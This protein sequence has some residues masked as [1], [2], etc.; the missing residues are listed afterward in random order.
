MAMPCTSSCSAAVTTSSTERLCPRWITSAPM[1]CRMR[2]MMLMAASW[3]SKSEAAVTKRTLFVGRYSARALNSA[4][5]S[6]MRGSCTSFDND[7][8]QRRVARR[9][10]QI[11]ALHRLLHHCGDHQIA[12]RFRICG[13]DG[14]RGP[15]CAGG[16]DGGRIRRLIGI[17]FL[18]R[19]EVA[20]FELPVLGRVVE[21]LLQTRALLLLGDVQHELENDGAGF[22]QHALEVVDVRIALLGLRLGDVAV[23]HRHQHVFIVAA[24]EDHDL[25]VARHALM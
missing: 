9:V 6:V 13:H 12:M 1:P 5:R 18:S 25:A 17:P 14:P 22:R 20:A 11:Q 16:A 3:P 23:D 2:R 10:A 8:V 21:P 7:L 4:E 24:V 19:L 15:G